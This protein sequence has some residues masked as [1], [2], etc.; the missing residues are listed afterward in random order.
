MRSIY[1]DDDEQLDAPRR[2]WSYWADQ[3]AAN[4]RSAL[5]CDD[6]D[7]WALSKVA[8]EIYGEES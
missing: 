2:D 7:W 6:A 5:G 8:R 3:Q 1:P 4:L